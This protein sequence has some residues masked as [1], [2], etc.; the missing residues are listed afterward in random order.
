MGN[1]CS[2]SDTSRG[3]QPAKLF[4]SH[5]QTSGAFQEWRRWLG[6]EP[7]S[8]KVSF[9]PFNDRGLTLLPMTKKYKVSLIWGCGL[10]QHFP[11]F[12]KMVTKSA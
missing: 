11:Q 8:L 7:E 10:L 3:P 1:C 2:H 12:V 5:Q 6:R 4:Q 9:P